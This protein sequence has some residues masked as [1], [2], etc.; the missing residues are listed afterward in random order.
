MDPIARDYDALASAY[1][2]EVSGELAHKPMDR[3]WLTDFAA[4]MAGR[5][6][7]ADL[8]CGPGHVTAF[9]AAAGAEVLG[10]DL[11][12]GMVKQARGAHPGLRFEVA[13]MR[14]LS[15]RFAGIVAMYALIHL[16]PEELAAALAACHACLEP[17]G[18]FRAAV[19]LGEGVLRPGELWGVPIALGFRMFAPGELESA[20][21]AAGF[22]VASS[23]VREPYPGVEYPSRRLYVTAFK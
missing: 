16:E 21:E 9:L 3:E 6:V 10:L 5:G 19:H 11:S 12:P 14:A 17:G 7:V 23:L 15:G 1:A 20:L 4:R 8:G 18:E 22:V 13:D 2:R